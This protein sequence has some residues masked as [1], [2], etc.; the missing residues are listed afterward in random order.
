MIYF[1]SDFHFNHENI[2]K[3][4]NRP[5]GSVQEMNDAL[6][7][8][9][10]RDVKPTDT[11]YYLGDFCFHPRADFEKFWNSLNGNK[12]FISGNHDFKLPETVTQHKLLE[13]RIAGRMVVMC[14]Y[15]LLQ[16]RDA[17]YGSLHLHGHLHGKRAQPNE[18]SMDVGFDAEDRHR[19]L[20]WDEIVKRL[21][22][23]PPLNRHGG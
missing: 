22:K 17:E 14:H 16:W 11:V 4:A 1:T 3:F 7:E 20:T 2:L 21:E 8:I 13:K 12:V 15:P 6:V 5:W 18:R 10:N 19:L 23:Y 9:W